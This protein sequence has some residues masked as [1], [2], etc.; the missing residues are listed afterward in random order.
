MAK[1]SDHLLNPPYRRDLVFEGAP[2]PKGSGPD[3]IAGA[4]TLRRYMYSEGRWGEY[5]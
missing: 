1:L 3:Q 2:Y 4:S 5:E